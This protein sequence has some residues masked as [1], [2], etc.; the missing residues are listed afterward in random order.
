[1]PVCGT[2]EGEARKHLIDHPIDSVEPLASSSPGP[3]DAPPLAPRR[4]FLR[5]V[6]WRWSD[7]LIGLAP[8]AAMR[9]AGVLIDPT[10]LST[11]ASWIW[12]PV[13]ILA[14]TWMLIYPLWIARR[15]KAEVPHLPR[16]RTIFVE[17]LIAAFSMMVSIVVLNVV[18]QF[19]T[20]FLGDQA[21]S[22]MPLEPIARSPNRVD[23][24]GLL[25]LSV[26]VAPVAEE[27]CFRGMLYSALRQRLH[28][29]VALPLQAVVFG[30]IH[31][32]GMADMANVALIGL[33][34]GLLYEWRR[35]LLAPVLMH[36]MICALGM[37]VMASGIAAPPRLGVYGETHEGGCLVTRV[38]PGS[39]AE[40]A[41]LQVGDVV[42]SLNGD[43]VAN[44]RSLTQAVR[45]KLVG[46]E[47]VVE[48][49]RGGEPHR[50]TAVLTKLRE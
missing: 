36:S 29:V 47:V 16:P 43:S 37:A 23:A 46:Q 2:S 38:V 27:V 7:V 10:S 48:F 19:L 3:A 9:A 49:I 20:H 26:F 1:M 39:A 6:P 30:L 15:R 32:F 18:F 12:L 14:Q 50:V 35:T 13:S 17:A 41:G 33:A 22:T 5:E 25:L 44:M 11:V 45:R 34:L 42:K 31:P 40:T 24:L 8:I 4:S 28:M 21:R